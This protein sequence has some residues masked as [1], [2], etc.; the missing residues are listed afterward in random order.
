MRMTYLTLCA[1]LAA[2]PASAQGLGDLLGR[3]ASGPVL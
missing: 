2:T 3:L 1:L